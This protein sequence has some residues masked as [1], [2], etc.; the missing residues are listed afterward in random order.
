MRALPDGIDRRDRETKGI[1]PGPAAKG[2]NDRDDGGADGGNRHSIRPMFS[3]VVHG[4]CTIPSMYRNAQAIEVDPSVVRPMR[5]DREAVAEFKS[6]RRRVRWSGPAD[7]A[8]FLVRGHEIP[9]HP[10]ARGT[11]FT[12]WHA[13]NSTATPP[14]AD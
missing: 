14:W 9:R 1:I 8:A 13:L 12:P 6:L 2:G 5:H 10:L 3:A 11:A 7:E 4:P